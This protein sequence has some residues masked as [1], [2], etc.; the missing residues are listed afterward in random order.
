MDNNLPNVVVMSQTWQ[1]LVIAAVSCH[2]HFLCCRYLVRTLICRFAP[3]SF[4]LETFNYTKYHIIGNINNLFM[5]LLACPN[6][7]LSF[8]PLPL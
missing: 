2:V 3:V 6:S 8:T 7:Y 1:W 5:L 4:S